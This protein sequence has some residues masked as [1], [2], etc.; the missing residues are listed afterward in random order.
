MEFIQMNTFS[1]LLK[2]EVLD[3]SNN[4]IYSIKDNSFNGLINLRDLYINGNEPYLKIEN[5]SFNQFET[6]RTIFLD[7]SILNNSFHKILFIDMIKKKN[8]IHNKTIIVWSYF[9]AFNLITLNEPFYDCGLVFELIRFNIQYNLKTES[10]FSDNLYNC[11]FNTIERNFSNSY[12]IQEKKITINY[13][14][15]YLGMLSYSFVVV[16][17]LILY[18]FF[19]KHCSFKFQ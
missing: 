1:N 9:K 18:L 6:I 14:F 7:K 8:F 5:S 13:F 19:Q 11:E 2:L 3:L 12:M 15:L 17:I 10:D 16:F 4:K